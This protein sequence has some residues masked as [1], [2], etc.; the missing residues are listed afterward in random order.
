MKQASYIKADSLANLIEALKAVLP[1]EP[2]AIDIV[3][4]G[5]YEYR[6]DGMTEEQ[7]EKLSAAPI[8]EIQVHRRPF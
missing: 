5:N 2:N 6:L 3:P 7:E 4:L 1:N 8:P